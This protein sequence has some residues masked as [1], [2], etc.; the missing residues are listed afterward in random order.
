MNPLQENGRPRL[1][2]YRLLAWLAV[3]VLAAGSG[4]QGTAARL[5]TAVLCLGLAGLAMGLHAWLERGGPRRRAWPAVALLEVI[6]AAVAVARI[7][8]TASPLLLLLAL[9]VVM[10]GLMRAVAGGLAAAA[11]AILALW[12]FAPGG[13][14]SGMSSGASPAG[15]RGAAALTATGGFQAA[16]LLLLGLCAGLLGRRVGQEVA[17]L[18]TTAAELEQ[19]RLDAETI[20]AHLAAGLICIDGEGRV[21]R[22]NREAERLLGPVPGGTLVG[23]HLL[24]LGAAPGCA[25]LVRHLGAQLSATVEETAE[26]AV[27]ATPVEAVTTPVRDA[28]GHPRGLVA[29]LTDLTG[30]RAQE[31]AR[32]RRERLAVIGELSAG[33]AHEIRNSLKPITGSVE[34]LRREL[35]AGDDGRDGLMEIILRE[36]ESLENFL[37]EFLAFARDRRLE[38]AEL[39][40][41]T[42]IGEELE[43]LN[44]LPGE[45][46]R[47]ARPPAAEAPLLVRA[48]R[49]CLRQ[50]V[51]N[52]GVNALE[53]GGAPIEVGWRR[54]GREAE[55]FVRDHG[56]GVAPEIR[57]RVFEPFFTT[58]PQGTGLGLAIARDLA[59]RL[60][61]R[62]ELTPAAGGGTRA[63]LRLPLS[64]DTIDAGRWTAPQEPA[65]RAA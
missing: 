55:I 17:A 62:L 30:R 36:A 24:H 3:A 59:D 21:S 26:V 6:A 20:V 9:P 7:G 43:S 61:G 14:S 33:L 45:A 32:R 60:G 34:L 50:I 31:E 52:L 4:E 1:T 38:L 54:D 44:A 28:G 49:G 40:I 16:A 11:F 51:R 27:G 2:T 56:P 22:A 23:A 15:L 58:K 41:D 10:W 25:D 37:T 48:D 29:L 57:G 39:P 53:A 65:A 18:R 42:V 5:V 13:A 8:P 46:F 47:L 63:S 12:L 19:T 35:P 64:G